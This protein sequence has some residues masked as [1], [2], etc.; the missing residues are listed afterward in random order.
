MYRYAF[1]KR[2]L[3]HTTLPVQLIIPYIYVADVTTSNGAQML[4]E[5]EFLEVGDLV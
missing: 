5:D 4:D 1:K 3:S 2:N